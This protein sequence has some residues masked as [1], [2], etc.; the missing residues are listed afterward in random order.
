MELN[1]IA[2]LDE[3][4]KALRDKYLKAQLDWVQAGYGTLDDIKNQSDK[5]IRGSWVDWYSD[6]THG[7]LSPDDFE[8]DNYDKDIVL[9][10]LNDKDIVPTRD[11]IVK[12][13]S[14]NLGGDEE[15]EENNNTD[16]EYK[17][18]D[19]TS[20]IYDEGFNRFMD[21]TYGTNLSSIAK[22]IIAN[23]LGRSL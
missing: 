6:P 16:P 20:E 19:G 13:V 10:I 2:N 4:K 9:K 18:L 8:E 5:D 1:D 14:D 22:N 3:I 17:Y 15:P 23:D 12:Y 7:G 11:E 21:E